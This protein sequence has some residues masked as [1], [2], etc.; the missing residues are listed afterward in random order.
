MKRLAAYSG[1]FL[2]NRQ[3]RDMLRIA[4]YDIQPP[5]ARN[6]DGVAVWGGRAVAARGHRAAARR[7]LPVVHIEDAFI[8]SVHHGWRERPLGLCIDPV[9]FYADA[10]TPSAL[11]NLLNEHRDLSPAEEARAAALRDLIIDKGFSKYNHI[12]DAPAAPPDA[13]FVLVADQVP[14]DASIAMGGAAAESFAAMLQA[15]LTEN[16]GRRVLIRRHP[17]A[18]VGH[19]TDLPDRVQFADPAAHP[20]ALLDQAGRVYCVTSQLGFDAIIRGHKPVVFGQPFYAGWGLSDDRNPI[21]RRRVGHDCL[22]L[23]HRVLIDYCVW[24]DPIRQQITDIETALSMLSARQNAIRATEGPV[25]AI[26]MRLWKHRHMRAFFPGARFADLP[27]P[28]RQ[29]LVWAGKETPEIADTAAHVG[30]PLS[31]VE[32]GFLRSAGLGAT[33]IPPLSLA[34]DDLGIYYDPARE[35]RLEQLITASVDLPEAAL[36][37][38]ARLRAQIVKTGVSKYNLSGKVPQVDGDRLRILVVGQVEDDASIRCGT[39]DIASNLSLIR[40]VRADFPD[41]FLA[42]KPHPDVESGLRVGAISEV[43]PVDAIWTDADVVAAI[44]AVDTVAT[45]TSLAG[46]EALLRGKKVI[47]YGQPFYAGWGLT[48]D[49]CGAPARRVARPGL[50]GLVHAALVDYPIYRDPVTGLFVR[51]EDVVWRLGSG[52]LGRTQRPVPVL[53]KLQG[54][55]AGFADYWR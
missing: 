34:V 33:L 44:S 36:Q 9:G 46:F 50:D 27:E 51:A 30:A 13:G 8:R 55:F 53:S 16:P 39:S 28:G 45:M 41:A 37:R 54:L 7:G 10:R 40:A 11:E 15:A 2:G 6:V 3:L 1:G 43:L 24:I 48:T 25:T 5:L 19:F 52:T 47:C 35:S 23:I 17:R 14:G 49:R 12:A 4:G 20:M 32:D 38:A 31:R 42:Y 18:G 29:A 21:A 22:R 26:G